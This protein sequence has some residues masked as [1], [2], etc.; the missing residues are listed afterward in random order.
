MKVM[1][2]ICSREAMGRVSFFSNRMFNKGIY[3]FDEPEA[4]LSP[5]RQLELLRTLKEVE[6]RRNAQVILIT[7]SP[8]LMAYPNADIYSFGYRGIM[9][10]VLEDTEH[11]RLLADFYKSPHKFIDEILAS[12]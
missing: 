4:A 2:E 7:H 10:C 12:S 6:L 3:L 11:Y 1:E 5:N 8:L 9:K